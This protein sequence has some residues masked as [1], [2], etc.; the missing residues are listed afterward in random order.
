MKLGKKAIAGIVDRTGKTFSKMV[1]MGVLEPELKNKLM[2][3][4]NAVMELSDTHDIGLLITALVSSMDLITLRSLMDSF[5]QIPEDMV[6]TQS[7]E[8]LE[9]EDTEI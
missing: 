4:F 5:H 7:I 9:D 8:Y 1:Q 6:M 2:V 3:I